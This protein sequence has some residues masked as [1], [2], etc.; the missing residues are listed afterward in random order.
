[1]QIARTETVTASMEGVT[2]A[3]AQMSGHLTAAAPALPAPAE[4]T[5][6]P[7]TCAINGAAPSQTLSC[8][9]DLAASGKAG[10]TQTVHVTSHTIWNSDHNSCGTYDNTAQVSATN[11]V[12]SPSAGASEDVLCPDLHITKTHDAASVNAGR[13]S[14]RS[15]TTP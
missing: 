4:G 11:V 10:D 1:M 6:G 15:P 3:M 14:K 2:A 12:D 13:N 9:G 8:N 5:S 7:L